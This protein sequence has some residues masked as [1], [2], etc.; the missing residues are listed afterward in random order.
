MSVALL[1]LGAA[2]LG[3][4]AQEVVFVGGATI[5][6]WITDPA[7]PPPRATK[8]VDVIVEVATRTDYYAFEER[9]RGAGFCDDE[10]TICR[11]RH[12]ESDLILDTMPTE[13]A[14]LGFE[15]RWQREAFPHADTVELPSGARI[16]AVSPPYL[17]ATKL[18]AYLGRGN[19]DLL[20]SRDFADIVAL[21]DGR[22]ELL[23]EIE[24][25]PEA[26][27]RYV[28][29]TLGSL[30]EEDRILDGIQAQLPPDA[31]S[32]ERG[33]DVVLPQLRQIVT[34]A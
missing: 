30:L 18:E 8:D 6:L 20:G 10:E 34:A 13:A 9:L 27:R 15:N 12:P 1:E 31:A 7:A 17:L 29:E 23:E 11:W 32:Q 14:I 33:E 26:L 21:L 5:T 3:D 25:S 28:G 4:L 19:G 2:A 22:A 24:A 16:G